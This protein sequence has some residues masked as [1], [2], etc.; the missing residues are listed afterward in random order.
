MGMAVCW[1]VVVLVLVVE[2]AAAA[3]RSRS[4][5]IACFSNADSRLIAPSKVPKKPPFDLEEE[6]GAFAEEKIGGVGTLPVV[7]SLMSL[8]LDGV[9]G[10]A[11][12]GVAAAATEAATAAAAD[13]T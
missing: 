1:V 13:A 12:V 4:L 5:D 11:D 6:A 10:V 7:T 9:E 2:S 3:F 8:T